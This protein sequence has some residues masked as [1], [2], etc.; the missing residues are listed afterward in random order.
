MVKI[1]KKI[2]LFS[3]QNW[4]NYLFSRIKKKTYKKVLTQN[5]RFVWQRP[6]CGQQMVTNNL[7]VGTTSA[8]DGSNIHARFTATQESKL[9]LETRAFVHFQTPTPSLWSSRMWSWISISLGFLTWV[10][11]LIWPKAQSQRLKLE[12]KPNQPKAKAKAKSSQTKHTC[13]PHIQAGLT[14][15]ECS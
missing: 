10:A 9:S 8:F 12:A 4:I 7:T 1:K 3:H 13:G 15:S 14:L 11:L 6:R 2:I 5:S